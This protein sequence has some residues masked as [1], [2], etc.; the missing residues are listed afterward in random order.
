MGW[1]GLDWTDVEM[2]RKTIAQLSRPDRIEQRLESESPMGT[3]AKEGRKEGREWKPGVVG[4]PYQMQNGNGW[5]RP[6]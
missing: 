2:G 3:L 1:D 6:R 5:F 4:T